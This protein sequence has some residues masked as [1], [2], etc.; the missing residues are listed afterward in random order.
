VKIGMILAAIRKGYGRRMTLAAEVI[1]F[2]L[3]GLTAKAMLGAGRAT[4]MA[5]RGG[6]DLPPMSARYTP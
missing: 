3:L 1:G 6:Q 2:Q 4:S 5:S